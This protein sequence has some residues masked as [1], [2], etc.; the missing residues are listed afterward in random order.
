MLNKLY[1]IVPVLFTGS[2][3][4]ADVLRINLKQGREK[5]RKVGMCDTWAQ[6]YLLPAEVNSTFPIRNLVNVISKVLLESHCF[7]FARVYLNTFH[8]P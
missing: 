3:K 4:Y 8:L 5:V 1:C 6:L 2:S 7:R